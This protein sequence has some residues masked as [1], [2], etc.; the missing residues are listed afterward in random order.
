MA[1]TLG[2]LF[3]SAISFI[4]IASTGNVP[5]ASAQESVEL[6]KVKWMRSLDEA[7]AISAKSGKPLFVQFQE[8]PG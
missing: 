1:K 5:N 8:V 3:L 2:I 6:G 4:M 7:K